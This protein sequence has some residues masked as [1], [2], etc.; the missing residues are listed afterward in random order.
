MKKLIQYLLENPQ[1]LTL[2]KDKKISLVGVS[3][4]EQQAILDVFNQPL[5]VKTMGW[6]F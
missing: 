6:R 2:L 5:K 4:I 3:A 1:M